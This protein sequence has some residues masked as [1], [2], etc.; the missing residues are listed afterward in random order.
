MAVTFGLGLKGWIG[1]CQ[2]KG[3]EGIQEAEERLKKVLKWV[4]DIFGSLD[5]NVCRFLY[6]K[7]LFCPLYSSTLRQP[8]GQL[9]RFLF[10]KENRGQRGEAMAGN[11][12]R[13]LKPEVLD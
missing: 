1:V 8:Q 3:A 12:V 2:P 10:S 13:A 6:Y 11:P 4:S 9:P 7:A 5:F